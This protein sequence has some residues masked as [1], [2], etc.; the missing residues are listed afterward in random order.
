MVKKSSVISII[1]KP[2]AGKSTLLN[3]LINHK[4]SIVTPKVQTTRSMIKGI[5]TKDNTQFVFID[6]PGIF[7]PKKN[8]EKVM[9]RCAWS[10]IIGADVVMLLVDSRDE[11][12]D[13]QLKMINRLKDSNVDL[14]ILLNKIDLTSLKKEQL[15]EYF[16]EILPNTKIFEI[17]AMN[18]DGVDN[19][20][21][22]L[23]QKSPEREWFYEEDDITTLPMRFLASEITRE[24]LFLELQDELPYN[25]TVD[26]ETWEEF[27]DG[28][29]KIRQVIIVARDSHK[30]IVLGKHGSMIKKIG[31]MSRV[32]I[33]EV[34]DIK[35]HLF[36]FVKVR[37]NWDHDL[38]RNIA[39]HI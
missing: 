5:V 4:I 11:L 26:T 23:I 34:L 36:L 7:E 31:Q 30:A 18:G 16:V 15:K 24:K 35:V 2:N 27:Q 6:T 33:T 20:I 32:S 38:S 8:L 17:S 22:F 9:V 19:L 39:L 14:I 3:R 37:E 13:F 21:E 25:L 28:S 12:S 29:V 1:G 10:S